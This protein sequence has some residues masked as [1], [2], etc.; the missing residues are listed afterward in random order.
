MLFSIGWLTVFVCCFYYSFAEV[1]IKG[2]YVCRLYCFGGLD[3]ICKFSEVMV[4]C[5]PPW[6]SI[7]VL[8]REIRG[9][10]IF[11]GRWSLTASDRLFILGRFVI[12]GVLK[13][14]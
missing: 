12:M 11:I 4:I 9:K 13:Q 8:C 2:V 5:F 10:F 7:C 14:R 6:G 1:I 3:A